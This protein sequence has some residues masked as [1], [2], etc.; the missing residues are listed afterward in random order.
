MI[1][2]EGVA[3]ISDVA[4]NVSG[5]M[6]NRH[7]A[8]AFADVGLREWRRQ[9]K[10]KGLL[11]GCFIVVADRFYPSSKR[12]HVCGEINKSLTLANRSW[13]CPG[14]GTA[15]DRDFNASKNLENLAVSSTER[16]INAS[17]SERLC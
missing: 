7:L 2:A 16:L 9:M 14:C 11:Y 6:R 10:Y 12:G 5:M 1:C 13:I 17:G 4:E 15:H 8:R 3:K